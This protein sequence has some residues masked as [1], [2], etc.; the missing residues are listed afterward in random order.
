[1]MVAL[2]VAWRIDAEATTTPPEASYE[3]TIVNEQAQPVPGASVAYAGTT[4]ITGANGVVNLQLRGPELAIVEAPGMLADGVVVGSRG[5]AEVTLQLLADTG[6]GGDRTVMHFAGNFMLG[7]RYVAGEGDEAP[8]VSDS[9]SARKVVADIA[10]LF[11]LADIST[12]NF[13][14]VIGSLSFADAYRGKRYLLQSPPE[15]LA[16]LDELGVDLVTLGNNHVNDWHEAGLSSTLRNLDTAGIARVGGGAT[17]DEAVQPAL[18][19]AGDLIIGTVSMTTVTGD[20][21]NDNLPNATAPKP[22][23]L[24][25]ADRWQY[26]LRDFGFGGEEDAAHVPVQARRPGT[27]WRLYEQ[28]EGELTAGDAADLWLEMVR[29]YPELQDWVARRGHGGAAHYSRAAVEE[30][31]ASARAQGADLVVVQLHGGYQFADVSSDYFGKATRASVDAGADLVIGHHPQV[32]QGFEIYKDTLI[33]Y[34]LGNFVFD[35]D[36][37]STHPSVILRTVF[38]G[39][40]L[41]DTT[42]YPVMIDGYRPVAVGGDVADGILQLMN[43]ASLQNAESIRLPDR[44]IGLTQ[45]EAPVTAAVINET[46]RGSVIPA[47]ANGSLA[48]SVDASVPTSTGGELIQIDSAATGLLIGRDIFGYGSL[49]DL[50]ADGTAT[51]GLEWSTPPQ[52]LVIDPSSPAGPWV[53]RLDRTSQHLNEIVARTGARVS[54]P[55]HRWFDSDGSPVDGTANHSVRVWAKRVGAGIPFIRVVFYE[56]D[57]TDPTRAP[58]STPLETIDIELP[59]VNDAEWH[60]LWVELPPLPEDANTALVGVGLAPPEFQ[61]GTVWVDGLQVIEWRSADETPQGV[62]VTTE[63]IMDS[64]PSERALTVAGSG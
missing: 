19:N 54:M 23:N 42:L 25:E 28:M 27:M 40:E 37:L 15:A 6:P 17:A 13:E 24:A 7:R 47:A 5:E 36:F 29:S 51:G 55:A 22:A 8:L 12:V 58:D 20:Y 50:Q 46:G 3:L 62:W 38:E 60:E 52:S 16:T 44:R 32:L 49:E 26:E 33:A 43:E 61:S 48:V 35:Q 30:A 2:V 59:L 53:V 34:S 45:T 14:S 11:S 4:A 18:V 41:I 1:M 56:F 9:D 10:P 31:V 21:V 63:Y 39:T 64:E 57:D